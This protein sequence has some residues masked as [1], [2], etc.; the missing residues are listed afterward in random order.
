MHFF[1]F[2]ERTN[3][4]LGNFDF[5]KNIWY[6]KIKNTLI[7]IGPNPK[8]QEL[9]F[10]KKYYIIYIQDKD[11]ENGKDMNTNFNFVVNEDDLLK[12]LESGATME[13]IKNIFNSAINKAADKQLQ[14]QKEEKEKLFQK[15]RDESLREALDHL[16]D[17]YDTFYDKDTIP[18]ADITPDVREYAANNNLLA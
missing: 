9:T 11:K 15:Q 18:H 13:Q 4:N 10:L 3:K 8:E 5:T 7:P 12:A 14:K 16:L 2:Q 17:W 6:N 1:T